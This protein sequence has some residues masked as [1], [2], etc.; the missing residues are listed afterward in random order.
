MDN[1]AERFLFYVTQLGVLLQL[2][3]VSH[4]TQEQPFARLVV[5]YI[6]KFPMLVLYH[7]FHIIRIFVPYQLSIHHIKKGIEQ[8]GFQMRAGRSYD[9]F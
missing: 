9:L 6:P 5:V 4:G 7:T 2:T 1:E 8:K 3:K